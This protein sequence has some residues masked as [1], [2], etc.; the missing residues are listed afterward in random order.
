MF[1]VLWSE[2][3]CCYIMNILSGMF[4]Q[5]QG[6]IYIV[7]Y[8]EC[9]KSLRDCLQF[10]S[11]ALKEGLDHKADIK[12]GIKIGWFLITSQIRFI[13]NSSVQRYE[14]I[15]ISSNAPCKE[16]HPFI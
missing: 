4:K 11:G 9:L 12:V 16:I 14:T 5:K 15:S 1:W 8:M 10:Y 7:C 2:L 6:T 13:Q 3:D